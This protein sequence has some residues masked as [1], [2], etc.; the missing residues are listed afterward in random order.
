M[1]ELQLGLSN[2]QTL[3]RRTWGIHAY[4]YCFSEYHDMYIPCVGYRLHCVE[5]Y[6]GSWCRLRDKKEQTEQ[7]FTLREE[8]FNYSWHGFKAYIFTYYIL[9]HH[10]LY[11][12]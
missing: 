10:V 1:N 3:T 2:S 9:S 6:S 4:M 11:D 8:P 5:R 7:D 12:R